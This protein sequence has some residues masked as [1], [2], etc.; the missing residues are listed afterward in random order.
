[1]QTLK[2]WNLTR[3][4]NRMLIGA[5]VA[6]CGQLYISVWAEGFRIST[7]AVL[8]PILLVALMRDSHR[9]DTGA[10]TALWVLGFRTLLDVF[11]G[12]SMQQALVREFPG[13]FFYFFYDTMLCLL[14]RDRRSVSGIW[15]WGSLWISDC[16]AN[17]LNLALSSRLSSLNEPMELLGLAG[18]A[19]VRATAAWIVLYLNRKYR[20]L[21]L[22][23]EHE[24]RYRRLFLMTAELKNELY[25]LKKNAEDIEAVM[26]NAYRLYESLSEE[27]EE[28]RSLALGVA[29]DVHEVKKDNL[30]I[31]R[32]IEEVVT[33]AYDDETMD[34][35]DILNI[36]EHSTRKLLGQQRADI[37]LESRLNRNIPVQAHYQLLSVLKNLVTNAVEAI[38]SADGRGLVRVECQVEEGTLTLS[39]SDDGPGISPRGKKMLFQMGYSTKF[40]PGTGNINRGVGLPAVKHI[41]EQLQ[42]TIDVVSE[43]GKGTCFTIIL[44]LVQV[45]G[46]TA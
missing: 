30:R 23:Q 46:G 45:T 13:G 9:P 26:S 28:E 32:G 21:L 44:P 33:E 36:L 25:L 18:L 20:Q 31:I 4:Q 17:V 5:L 10:V 11:Q 39:V 6:L 35:R 12:V 38:Q 22:H 27:N 7:A 40:D 16:T 15:L 29:R 34:L 42:G 41:V 37:R 8:Y 14:V 43:V 19:L 3:A 24:E 2:K 1:M